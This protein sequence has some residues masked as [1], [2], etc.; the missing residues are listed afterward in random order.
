MAFEL[1]KRLFGNSDDRRRGMRFNPREGLRVL[2]IDDSATIV[3]VLNKML[4][5]NGY[6]VLK[7]AD[8][9][10]GIEIA[11]SEK[12]DLVFLDIVLPGMNGFAALRALRRDPVTQKIPVIMISGNMQATEQFYAQ[13]IGADDFMK[14]PFGRG[15]VFTRIQKLVEAGRLAHHDTASAPAPLPAAPEDACVPD[16]GMPDARDLEAAKAAPAV[17]RDSIPSFAAPAGT[18]REP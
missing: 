12:P 18:Y 11:R 10:T 15:E 17:V 4:R 1:F 5:Q 13:R 16:I 2:V 9:E 8:G 6:E 3:A 7:A 14:K